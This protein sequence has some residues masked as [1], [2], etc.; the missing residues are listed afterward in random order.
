MSAR[1]TF[2]AVGDIMIGES[3]A[4]KFGPR[5]QS[6]KHGFDFPFR[7]VKPVFD[8]LD[9][10]TGNLETAVSDIG[11]RRGLVE[12]SI[13]RGNQKSLDALHSSGFKVLSVANNHT[14]QHGSDVF[15]DTAEAVRKAGIHPIGLAED[16]GSNFEVVNCNGMRI[17]F[18]GYS[19]WPSERHDDENQCFAMVRDQKEVIFRDIG[20]WK[21]E[22]DHLCVSIHWGFEFVNAASDDQIELGHAMIDAGVSCV[23]GHHPHVLQGVEMFGRGL[24]A[25]SLGNF[26]FDTVNP[27]TRSSMILVVKLDDD[28]VVGFDT[29]PVRINSSFQPEPLDD[30][31]RREFEETFGK[32]CAYITDP[33][34]AHLRTVSACME[35]SV[36]GKMGNQQ[37]TNRFFMQNIH[38]YPLK[39]VVN[40]IF[41]KVRNYLSGTYKKD[42]YMQNIEHQ[43]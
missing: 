30:N 31:G 3:V 29:V 24:I 4:I 20:R 9:F 10:V 23:L 25:Y 5:S 1:V 8:G 35:E 15:F 6:E 42:S 12:S 19:L 2:G 16:C 34:Y 13:F 21:D 26:V 38:R 28:K 27:A 17:G 37:F 32:Y 40:K 43:R 39:V 33:K 7:L 11:Y 22:V 14:L 41:R 18:L 36:R